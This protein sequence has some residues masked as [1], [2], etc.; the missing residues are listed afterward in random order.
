[1]I[2]IKI[3]IHFSIWR[4]EVLLWLNWYRNTHFQVLSKVKRD[5]TS[6]LSELKWNALK[7][8]ISITYI[9]HPSRQN[10][11]LMNIVSVVDKF[12]Q[13]SLVH[14]WVTPDDTVK[15]TILISCFV[16]WKDK[17]WYIEAIVEEF[18]K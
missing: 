14:Y 6:K 8:P 7:T 15:E 9:L 2:S 18:I 1:M 3:P 5:F 17:E 16:W 11:D 10:Q 13:D 4:K 12:F